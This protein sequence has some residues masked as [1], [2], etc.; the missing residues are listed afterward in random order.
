L[1]AARPDLKISLNGGLTSIE[2]SLAILPRFDGVMLGRLAYHSPEVLGRV[3]R[4]FF[5]EETPLVDGFEAVSRYRPYM[6]KTLDSGIHLHAMTRHMLGLFGGQKGARRWRRI[7]SENAPG[8][9]G[10]GALSILDEALEGVAHHA[11]Q[12]IETSV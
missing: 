1:K 7:L 6:E 12:K 9:K 3:D 2:D 11:Q 5:D 4:E 10:I 8:A